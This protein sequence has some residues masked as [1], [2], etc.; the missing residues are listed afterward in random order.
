[1][2]LAEDYKLVESSNKRLDLP[3][4]KC[5]LSL[6]NYDIWMVVCPHHLMKGLSELHINLA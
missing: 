6:S 4:Q 5:N 3:K 2:I 1:M